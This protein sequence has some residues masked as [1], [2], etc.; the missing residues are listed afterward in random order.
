MTVQVRPIRETDIEGF[1]AVLD[2]VASE[3]KYLATVRAPPLKQV[4]EFVVGNIRGNNAMYVAETE[5]E[6]VGWA[7]AVRGTRDSTR[8]TASVG[9]GIIEAYRG[10]GIGR[11]LL[12][13]VIEHC[14]RARLVRI[15]L[16]VLVDNAR[17]IALY[18]KLGFHYEGRLRKAR[19]IC[20]EYKD[21]FHM[22]LLHPSLTTST[23]FSR[24]T[25]SE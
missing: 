10:Q 19:L 25:G 5:G 14:W 8:H 21:V 4:R 20:G 11:R 23:P 17:A 24:G 13:R 22:A 3:K 1:R 15:E 6:I 9:M 7:D 12:E 18:E 2:A 16:E